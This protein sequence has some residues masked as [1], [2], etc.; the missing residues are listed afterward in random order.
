MKKKPCSK[1]GVEKELSEFYKQNKTRIGVNAE[2][3]ECWKKR[4]K[5]K[6][7]ENW[8]KYIIG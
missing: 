6:E 1:C 7:D 4:L 5:K 3:K 8:L 2:C